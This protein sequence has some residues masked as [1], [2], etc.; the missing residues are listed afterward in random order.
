MKKSIFLL[1]AILV[2]MLG[3]TAGNAHKRQ[4]VHNFLNSQIGVMTYDDAIQRYGPPF[5]CANGRGV[6]VCLWHFK[7]RSIGLDSY[8]R[9]QLTFDSASNRLVDWR[10]EWK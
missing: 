3:C 4:Q 1:A 9:L 6:M 10:H 5:K 2:V 7:P 8:D